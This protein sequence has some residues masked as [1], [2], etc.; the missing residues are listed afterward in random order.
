LHE[1]V[2]LQVPLPEGECLVQADVGQIEQV[3]INLAINAQDAMP[4]GGTLTI[5]VAASPSRP[6]RASPIDAPAAPTVEIVVA[7]TGCGMDAR[8]REHAFEPFFTTKEP[9][10]GTGLGL[11]MVHGI[12]EQ[13]G[14]TIEVRS[15][16]GAGTTFTITLP[17]SAAGAPDATAAPALAGPTGTETVLVVE[18]TAP[19]LSVMVSLLRRH[20]YT[21][22]AAESG[23]AA[24]A[25]LDRHAGPIDVLLTDVV[26]PGMSG[27]ELAAQVAARVPG[28]KV[29]FMS[30]HELSVVASHGVVDERAAL[31]AKPFSRVE[32]TTSVR[33]L[34]DGG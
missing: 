26:M 20:G 23:P 21:V 15:E 16:P 28:V 14:G 17:A 19:A 24:L 32:L 4:Q 9:G 8:T 33:R 7:D 29:L 27:T 12:V 2:R 34:L 30:G 1:D 3:L 25:I 10:K 5:A 22:L 6:N 13:H 11:A 31:L 18:D